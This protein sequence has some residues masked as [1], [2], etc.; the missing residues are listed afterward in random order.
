MCSAHIVVDDVVERLAMSGHTQPNTQ[1]CHELLCVHN[2]KVQERADGTPFFNT[3]R[4]SHSFEQG[5]FPRS[6][7]RSSKVD[8]SLG[9][10]R[11]KASFSSFG[12]FGPATDFSGAEHDLSPSFLRFVASET[13]K[14]EDVPRHRA[15]FSNTH[16]SASGERGT[17]LEDAV[18]EELSCLNQQYFVTTS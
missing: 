12:R 6:N 7:K 3:C 15:K 5:P 14:T 10:F 1:S 13:R 9:S 18:E 17:K 11:R 16:R 4:V 8:C 2:G